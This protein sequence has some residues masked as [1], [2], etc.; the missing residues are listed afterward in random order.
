VWTRFGVWNRWVFDSRTCQ[1]IDNLPGAHH[2]NGYTTARGLWVPLVLLWIQVGHQTHITKTQ[3]YYETIL[4]FICFMCHC[5]WLT[6]HHT[7][8]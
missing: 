2:Y 7:A 8:L 3:S 4:Y 5:H 6:A 1:R